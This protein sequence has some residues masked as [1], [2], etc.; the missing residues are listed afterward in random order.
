MKKIIG[1]IAIAALLGG[2]IYFF[3]NAVL[4]FKKQET[5]QSKL[6]YATFKAKHP[7][8]IIIKTPDSEVE[9]ERP[10]QGKWTLANAEGYPADESAIDKMMETVLT[11]TKDQLISNNPQN[12]DKFD[13]NPAK[14][15]EVII[16][17]RNDREIAHF[18]VGKMGPS[19]GTQYFRKNNLDEVYLV[20]QNLSQH[21]TR[22]LD[23]WKDRTIIKIEQAEIEAVRVLDNYD[24]LRS[25]SGW[26]LNEE[27]IAQ[28]EVNVILGALTDLRTIDFPTEEVELTPE[29]ADNVITI[30]AKDKTHTIYLKQEEEG[31]NYYLILAGNST[32][33]KISS[34][35]KGEIIPELTEMLIREIE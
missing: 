20:N 35:K 24:L 21:F 6:L 11:I 10:W 7:H 14:G 32:L 15:V 22:P 2:Y 18:W 33:F 30:E 29:T 28:E 34:V 26:T 8:R 3:D 12:W 5:E 9:L 13:V 1:F 19:F 4:D 31:E 16:K 23:A 27:E 17:E 25:G